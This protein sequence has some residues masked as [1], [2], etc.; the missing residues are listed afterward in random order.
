MTVFPGIPELLED[1][2]ALELS[3]NIYKKTGCF[4]FL[5]P[6]E[7]IIVYHPKKN[8]NPFYIILCGLYSLYHDFGKFALNWFLNCISDVSLQVQ[9]KQH[10]MFIE[11][12]R[13]CIAHGT[14]CSLEIEGFYREIKNTLSIYTPIEKWKKEDWIKICEFLTRKS[15]D[16]YR[17]LESCAND[18][19]DVLASRANDFQTYVFSELITDKVL[20]EQCTQTTESSR[21]NVDLNHYDITTRLNRILEELCKGSPRNTELIQKMKK[22]NTGKTNDLYALIIRECDEILYPSPTNRL[23]VSMSKIG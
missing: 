22:C 10:K 18:S 19:T 6:T 16:L 14:Y 7:K 2:K 4:P 17:Y 9:L 5:K 20:L 23:M 8:E 3:N 13:C 21:G 11:T 15:N 12:L 1:K